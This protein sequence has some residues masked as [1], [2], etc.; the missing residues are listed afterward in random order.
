[1]HTINPLHFAIVANTNVDEAAIEEMMKYTDDDSDDEE[2][3]S[4]EDSK[5]KL[6][7]LV[8]KEPYKSGHLWTLGWR[9][10]LCKCAK[11]KEM[12]ASLDVSFLIDKEDET[13]RYFDDEEDETQTKI[14]EAIQKF[15]EWLLQ[16]DPIERDEMFGAGPEVVKQKMKEHFAES[17]LDEAS[18]PET[19]GEVNEFLA[20][21]QLL[22]QLLQAFTEFVLEAEGGTDYLLDVDAL[23]SIMTSVGVADDQDA[24]GLVASAIVDSPKQ[25]AVSLKE[26]E[27]EVNEN[28]NSKLAE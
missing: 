6:E 22:D 19:S 5:C 15:E 24:Q 28:E 20:D 18:K 10:K 12:Y 27:N 3:K 11:C 21:D 9:G 14:C 7:K 2:V 16:M 4:L 23:K 8:K 26:R 25:E 13:R 17:S 1:M